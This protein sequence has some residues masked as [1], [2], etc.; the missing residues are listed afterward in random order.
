[1]L[2]ILDPPKILDSRRRKRE[3]DIIFCT[4]FKIV[5]LLF[6]GPIRALLKSL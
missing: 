3:N 1:M 6:Q 2:E 5:A 4:M